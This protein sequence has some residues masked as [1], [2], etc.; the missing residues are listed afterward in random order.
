VHDLL[1]EL[2]LADPIAL[3]TLTVGMLLDHTA[4]WRGDTLADSGWGDDALE[5]ATAEILAK[6]QQVNPPGSVVSYANSAVL[7][8]GRVLEVVSGQDYAAAV[9][10][11]V[12]DP[13]CMT[14]TCFFPWQAHGRRIAVGHRVQDGRPTVVPG[15]PVRR[16]N[17]PA[18]GAASG[19]ADQVRWAKFCLDGTSEGT[20]P[21]RDQTRLLM[22]QPRAQ[23]RSMI[24]GVGISW[25]LQQRGG[26]RLVTHGGNLN[27]LHLG[28]FVLAPDHGLAVLALSNSRGGSEAGRALVDLV[29]AEELGC[30]P[31]ALPTVPAPHGLVGC[32][33]G[34]AWQQQITSREGKLFI[35]MVLPAG[36]PEELVALFV[37]PPAELVAVGNDQLA[38]AS[39]PCEVAG[40]VGRDSHGD[41]AWL[42]WGMRVHLRTDRQIERVDP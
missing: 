39:R 16:A 31:P 27:N 41:V 40:D 1:P 11:F 33:E 5:R 30:N 12:L 23:A 20:T 19:L 38:L 15:W 25:L 24:T 17:G 34:G 8:A 3:E 13:L 42:R 29:L 14:T 2:Q 7:L 26:V 32:Y 6:E 18:G 28:T 22:Q 35:Q 21:L 9:Q 10:E 4:G 36:A 37:Q